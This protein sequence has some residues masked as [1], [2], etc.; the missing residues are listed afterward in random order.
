LQP[1]CAQLQPLL[2]FE[3][4]PQLLSSNSRLR[5]AAVLLPRLVVLRLLPL[6]L[7]LPAPRVAVL[8]ELHGVERLLPQRDDVLL[9]RHDGGLLLLQSDELRLPPLLLLRIRLLLEPRSQLLFW[10]LPLRIDG[11]PILPSLFAAWLLPRV[12]ELLHLPVRR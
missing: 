8:H 5:D 10:R 9:L 2:S 12:I 1:A 3:L 4:A 7:K 11:A 6:A